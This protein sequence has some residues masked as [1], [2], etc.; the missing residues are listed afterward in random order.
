ILIRAGADPTLADYRGNTPL[1]AAARAGHAAGLSYLL[2]LS[3]V[4][5][6]I[7]RHNDRRASAL[8]LAVHGNHLLAA[9]LLLSHGAHADT[10]GNGQTALQL[11]LKHD[12][13]QMANLLH[14]SG[15]SNYIRYASHHRLQEGRRKLNGGQP[16][17]AI[18][19]L[20]TV[21]TLQPDNARAFYL[22]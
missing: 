2:S 6:G 19:A 5:A 1:M 4:R 21:I 17:A 18:N 11:A 9:R 3:P 12:H 7:E 14:A 8:L 10:A 20:S 13:E 16:E 15:A 22:R